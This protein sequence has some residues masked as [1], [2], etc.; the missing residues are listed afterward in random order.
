MNGIIVVNKKSSMSSASVVNRIKHI[1]GEKC[2]HLGTLDPLAE[3]VLPVAIGRA[4]KLFDLFLNKTKT[5]ITQIRFGYMTDTLDEEGEVICTSQYIPKK[6]DIER[7][8][9]ENLLGDIMQLPPAYS[10]K[11]VDGKRSY[12][13][14]RHG[15]EVHLS[16]VPVTIYSFDVLRKIDENTYECRVVCSSGTYIRSLCRDVG[17]LLSSCATM[18]HL[19]RTHCGAFDIDHA[20]DLDEITE[21][22]FS[23]F[24]ILL[25][26]I[27][28]DYP[29]IDITKIE[30]K[31][32]IDGKKIKPNL[33]KNAKNIEKIDKNQIICVFLDEKLIGL[34]KVIDGFFKIFI[35]T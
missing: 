33:L 31:N 5:Y 14:A 30:Y 19:L 16:P 27:F 10:A 25:E 2:G 23:S 13:I 34:A 17:A 21:G 3:G 24:V 11:K 6:E 29:R 26:D 15:G 1:T 20:V 18:H 35:Y 4:T 32:L 8:I 9:A 12:S 28:L 7:V 22:N